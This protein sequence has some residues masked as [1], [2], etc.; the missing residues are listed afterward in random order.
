MRIA[1]LI[2]SGLLGA[3]GARADRMDDIAAIHVE[4]IG[5]RARIEALGAL[6]ATGQVVTGGQRARFVL[7]AARPNR[8]QL[9][10]EAGGRTLVQGIL[11]PYE[12]TV[13]VDGR[14]SQ[15]TKIDAIDANPEISP[16]TFARP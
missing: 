13:E 7:I 12:I 15:R 4:A 8:I 9:E 10:T 14:V 2:L 11:L 16:A 3:A 6:R 5:G 1:S